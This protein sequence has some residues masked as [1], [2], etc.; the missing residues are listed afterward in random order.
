MTLR[1]SH[2]IASSAGSQPIA[3]AKVAVSHAQ[4]WHVA[5]TTVLHDLMVDATT[6]PDLLIV[7]VSPIWE[8]SFPQLIAALRRNTEAKHLIGCSA[9]GVIANDICHESVPGISVIGF[10]LPDAILTTRY[11]PA[12]Q[13]GPVAWPFADALW[14]DETNGV[15][16]FA[17]PYRTDAQSILVGLREIAPNVPF[18]GALA[19]TI[20]PDRR[21]WIFHDDTCVSNGIVLLALS[22][23]YDLRV[24]VSQ[25]G[26]IVG[27]AW[28]ISA[29]DGNRIFE[30][31]GRP[32]RDVL[33]ETRDA[34]GDGD[35]LVGFP[36]SEYRDTFARDDFVLR[37]I[38]NVDD[39]DGSIAVGSIPRVGQ[40]VQFFVR[41]ADVGTQT[42]ESN[43]QQLVDSGE[44]AVG[45]IL[46]SCK[47][48][49]INMFGRSDHD[50]HLMHRYL[51]HVPVGGL[52][53]VGEL[54]PVQGVPAF[55]AFAAAVGV[56]L[57]RRR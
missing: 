19:S 55:N 35:F 43:L 45:G 41:D 23:P 30:I 46:C 15:I 16:M 39:E 10:W 17:D 18:V 34:A 6:A 36:V 31:S 5:V 14:P 38:L 52:Y 28:T 32:A 33:N 20:R 26:E 51:P 49:G 1:Y 37:A 56:I 4:R 13:D 27:E 48:R 42:M 29:V 44:D 57:D 7:F 11:M 2:P 24:F 22:G 9:A 25:A 54:G 40:T 12:N 8:R 53:S 47:A 50:A 3:I 21:T